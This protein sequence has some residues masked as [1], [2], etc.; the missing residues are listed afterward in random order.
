[1]SSQNKKNKEK[2]AYSYHGFAL[3]EHES[4][5]KRLLYL[6]EAL[7]IELDNI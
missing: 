1:M 6:V 2:N 4:K 5:L 7:T 3:K